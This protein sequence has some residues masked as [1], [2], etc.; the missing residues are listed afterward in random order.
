MAKN[1]IIPISLPVS[2]PNDFFSRGSLE[3]TDCEIIP[4]DTP[5]NYLHPCSIL[6]FIVHAFDL[7]T[8]LRQERSTKQ[9]TMYLCGVH[10]KLVHV[11]H[12][13]S[14]SIHSCMLKLCLSTPVRHCRV[15][16]RSETSDTQL[17]VSWPNVA[18]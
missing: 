11:K 6:P 12:R 7:C 17:V 13:V 15:F 10:A 18:C 1:P 5:K 8:S 4:L 3:S 14:L 2:D 9:N 16:S